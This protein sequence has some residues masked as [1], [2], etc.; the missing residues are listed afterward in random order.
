MDWKNLKSPNF[1]FLVF[2]QFY[3]YRIKF[4]IL[5]VICDFVVVYRKWRDTENG[6]YDGLHL[7]NIEPPLKKLGLF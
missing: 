5:I 2:V 6:V 4:H 1:C 7:K 3:T